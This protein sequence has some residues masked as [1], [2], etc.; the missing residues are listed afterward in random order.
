MRIHIVPGLGH[1]DLF[2]IL[3]GFRVAKAVL[4]E[5]RGHFMDPG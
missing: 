5:G 1:A 2:E 4:V 3:V